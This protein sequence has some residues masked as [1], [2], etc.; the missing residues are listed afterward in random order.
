MLQKYLR[1]FDWCLASFRLGIALLVSELL[2]GSCIGLGASSP[3]LYFYYDDWNYISGCLWTGILSPLALLLT[4]CF[5]ILAYLLAY[6]ERPTRIPALLCSFVI[7]ALTISV[8][9]MSAK[10]MQLTMLPPIL[11][12]LT[13]LTMTASLLFQPQ[14]AEE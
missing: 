14:N 5:L 1:Q 10:R 13:L 3:G 12:G 4:I 7:F 8:C 6:R 11:A 9:A 2:P